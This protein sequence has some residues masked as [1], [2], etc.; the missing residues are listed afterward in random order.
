V[1]GA[2]V[3]GVVFCVPNEK[4]FPAGAG[5]EDPKPGVVV[6]PPNPIIHGNNIIRTP[7]SFI[8]TYSSCKCDCCTKHG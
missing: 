3:A 5:V 2:D 4:V 8:Y 1:A 7:G 6:E